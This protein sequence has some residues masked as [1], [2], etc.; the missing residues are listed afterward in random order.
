MYY[1]NGALFAKVSIYLLFNYF[2]MLLVLHFLVDQTYFYS[3]KNSF[4][5]TVYL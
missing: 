3:V 1:F 5:T 2:N 4:S